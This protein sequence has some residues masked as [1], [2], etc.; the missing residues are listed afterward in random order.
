MRTASSN[1][2]P[3]V[4]SKSIAKP[5]PAISSGKA[6]RA[7]GSAAAT[8]DDAASDLRAF[9]SQAAVDNIMDGNHSALPTGAEPASSHAAP[10]ARTRP[11]TASQSSSSAQDT[12]PKGD[13]VSAANNC[14]ASLSVASA[15]SAHSSG[16]QS[17]A[18]QSAPAAAA[19]TPDAA[20]GAHPAAAPPA[21]AGFAPPSQSSAPASAPPQPQV[22][23]HTIPDPL[24]LVDSGQLRVTA[25]NSELKIS[26]QLPEL[27]KVE[28]RAVTAH[29][30]T[31]A[32]LT[33]FRH[34]A[35]PVF[36]AERTGLEQ[37]LKSRDVILGSLDAHAQNSQPQGQ[38]AGQQ[39]Q[40][41]SASA[42]SSDGTASIV[43]P[44][45][46]SATTEAGNAGFLPDYSS[47]SVR[48]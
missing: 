43:T 24:P 29:D 2:V 10:F 19:A 14:D 20:F 26:V 16:F 22:P 21:S 3:S 12:P 9:N 13:G 42:Q 39:R 23:T 31:T 34:D 32:H 8:G 18:G 7:I 4:S 15:V 45:T 36:A 25:N 47:I 46:L 17:A 44:A 41:G 35:L 27:G 40:Q 1:A 37:A 5:Q 48:A 28:V 38:S 6:D 11:Q 33:A 30:V